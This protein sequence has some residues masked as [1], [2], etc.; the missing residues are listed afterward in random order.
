M[1]LK[2]LESFVAVVE[3]KSFTRAAQK[4][5]ITQPA[6]SFQIKA[7]EEHL[8]IQLLDR[9][10]QEVALTE[11][12]E[13]LY[14]EAKKILLFYGE[15]VNG[16]DQLKNL[17][18]GVLKLGASTIPGE[19]ILPQYL[20]EFNKFYPQVELSLKVGSTQQVM[21]WLKERVIDLGVIGAAVELPGIRLLPFLEDE[22]VLITPADSGWK[23]QQVVTVDQLA[24]YKFI[25][26]E[27]GSGTRTVI[28]RILAQQGLE[29]D[30]LKVVMELGTTRAVL[31]AVSAGLG[32]SFVS[33]WAAN[34]LLEFNKLKQMHVEGIDLK[35]QLYLIISEQHYLSVIGNKFL[36]FVMNS[37]HLSMD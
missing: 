33:K 1:N 30:K 17:E 37:N 27:K 21:E 23:N 10:D 24:S 16:I 9:T 32:I 13:I 15:I 4:M 19:Y 2:Q 25:L 6:I 7:L 14:R 22:L 31:T 18:A 12:G 36:D 8:G 28:E 34:D 29:V 26:R 35:R 3:A 20:G 5:F 11:G